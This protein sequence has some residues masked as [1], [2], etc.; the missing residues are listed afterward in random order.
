MQ[1]TVQQT[2][3]SKTESIH[4]VEPKSTTRHTSPPFPDINVRT[5]HTD[6]IQTILSNNSRLNYQAPITDSIDTSNNQECLL[7]RSGYS[8]HLVDSLKQRIKTSTFI[9]Q[10]YASRGYH[11][12]SI[13]A[14]MHDP[15]Q[16]IFAATIGEIIVGTVTL[17]IDSD[18]GL[19]A[20][21][22]YQQEIDSFRSADRIVCELSK[23]AMD[24]QYSTKEIIASLFQIAYI[25]AR[26]VHKATDFFCEV[27]PRHAAP[28]KRLFGFRKIGKL[29]SCPRVNAPAV[30]LHLG[31]DYIKAQTVACAESCKQEARSIYPYFLSQL[32][33]RRISNKIWHLFA[34]NGKAAVT[35]TPSSDLLYM[36]PI[37]QYR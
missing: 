28:Q 31:L 2:C 20:D 4:L 33:E 12:E 15:N 34:L 25:Y 14:F 23:F 11:T 26:N 5:P 16:V 7:K 6:K 37:P 35:N 13:T 22:L 17:G 8:I 9:K 18:Q 29:R 10:M 3:K 21:E 1:N 30:L 19:L 24:P 36:L 27:N 32:E